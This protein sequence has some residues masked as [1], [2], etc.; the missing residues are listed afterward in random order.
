MTHTAALQAGK[1]RDG[2]T[3]GRR[4]GGRGRLTQSGQVCDEVTMINGRRPAIMQATC[5]RDIKPSASRRLSWTV[6]RR[7][8]GRTRR[9]SCMGAQRARRHSIRRQ[10][11]QSSVCRLGVV[12]FI[13]PPPFSGPSPAADDQ[14]AVALR[15]VINQASNMH[16][17]IVQRR[18]TQQY[19]NCTE[20]IYRATLTFLGLSAALLCV[21]HYYYYYKICIALKFKHA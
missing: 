3:D 4:E 11:Q 6:R 19:N 20:G 10:C 21:L 7:A 5:H 9:V 2:R 16:A 12:Q 8:R 17:A 13:H 18:A 15:P 1:Q 14:L